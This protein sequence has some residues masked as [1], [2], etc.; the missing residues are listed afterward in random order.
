MSRRGRL[1]ALPA[2]DRVVVSF[3]DAF[4]YFAAAYGLTI[5]GSIVD[6][7]GQDP[8]AGDLADLI[9][10]IRTSGAKAVFAEAQ[11]SPKL[12]E[13]IAGETGLAV[14]TNLHTD[15]L[16]DPPADTYVGL[17]RSNADE[18]VQALTGG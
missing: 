3:H 18:I 8:N 2:A 12:A 11:F 6:A 14:V 15:S 13:T 9:S 10:K 16:G 4:P 7:P 1:A 17:M 5:V